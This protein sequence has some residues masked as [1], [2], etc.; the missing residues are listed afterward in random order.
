M[1]DA[2]ASCGMRV[3]RRRRGA[4]VLVEVREARALVG[5]LRREGSGA[6]SASKNEASFVVLL[7]VYNT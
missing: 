5:V 1:L 3:A 2:V 4:H 6:S 7:S